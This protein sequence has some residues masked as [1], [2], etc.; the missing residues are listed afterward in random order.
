M[1]VMLLCHTDDMLSRPYEI[2]T[3]VASY[4]EVSESYEIGILW[5]CHTNEM[6]SPTY[7]IATDLMSYGR[8]NKSYV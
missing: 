4:R 6:L 8:V 7:E 5:L 1:S 2:N 3:L